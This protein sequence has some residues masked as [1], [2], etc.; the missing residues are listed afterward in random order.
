MVGVFLLVIAAVAVFFVFR[1][2]NADDKTIEQQKSQLPVEQELGIRNK[3]LGTTAEAQK[4]PIPKE[5]NLKVP[6]TSQAPTGNWDRQHEE[7][8][9]EASMLMANRYF[10]NRAIDN[11]TDAETGMAQLVDWENANIGVSDSMTAEQTAETLSKMLNLKTKM[12]TNPVIEDIKNAISKNQLVLVPVA[13]R[14]VGNPF[15]TSPGPLYHMLVIKGYTETQF[16]TNDPGTKR[17]EN[18]PYGF[19]VILDANHDWNNGDVNNGSHT[20]VLVSK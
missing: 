3:E 2:L 5:L 12:I 10:E 19:N 18:Y 8:C 4:T 11:S 7:N 20:I 1:G 6:F 17:G 16:I 13:G 14:L 15:Y 9:E